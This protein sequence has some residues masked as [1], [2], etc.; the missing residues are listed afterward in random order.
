MDQ[1]WNE[2]LRACVLNAFRHCHSVFHKVHQAVGRPPSV[3]QE[4]ARKPIEILIPCDAEATYDSNDVQH[5]LSPEFAR[6]TSRSDQL[7]TLQGQIKRLS[8][9]NQKG[10]QN[11]IHATIHSEAAYDDVDGY[12]QGP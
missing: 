8:L 6:P 12:W 1:T 10:Y 7:H 3:H 4:Y 2:A 9:R 11:S 5:T